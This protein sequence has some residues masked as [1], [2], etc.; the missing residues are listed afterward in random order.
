MRNFVIA[1]ALSLATVGTV[2]AAAL[3]G[4]F[5]MFDPN[6]N[7]VTDLSWGTVCDEQ[8]TGTIVT[9]ANGDGTFAVSSPQSFFGDLWFAHDGVTFGPGTHTFDTIEGGVY[10][11]I[12]VAPG[13]IGGHL[14]FDWGSASAVT[15]C[16]ITNCDIDVVNIWDVTLSSVDASTILK[17]YISTDN[18]GRATGDPNLP[19]DPYDLQDGILGNKIIDV[20]FFGFGPNFNFSAQEPDSTPPV[21]TLIG[22]N[23]QSVVIGDT[24]T[25][26]GADCVDAAPQQAFTYTP[27]ITGT[28]DTATLGDYIVT[29]NC[30]DAN[31]NSATPVTRTVSVVPADAVATLLGSTPVNYECEDTVATYVDAGAEC[32]DPEDG[33]WSDTVLGIPGTLIELTG[34]PFIETAPGGPH[35]LTWTCTDTDSNTGTAIREVNVVDTL[36]PV[37]GPF[38]QKDP[39]GTLLGDVLTLETNDEVAYANLNPTLESVTDSCDTTL[40]PLVMTGDTVDFVIVSGDVKTSTLNYTTTDA[41]GNV[42]NTP[43]TVNV[44]RSE[45][46][47]TLIGSAQLVLNVGDAYVEQGMDVHDEQDG[48]LTAVTTSGITTGVGAGA[49]DLTHNIVIRDA[50][51]T[52]VQSVDTSISGVIYTILYDVTDSDLNVATQVIRTVNVGGVFADGSNFTM[53]QAKGDT[54]G[55]TNDVIFDW[56]QSLNTAESDTNF[57]MEIST[58]TP[59]PFNGAVWVAHHIRAFG[60]GTYY[61]ETDNSVCT[62]AVLQATG[63]PGTAGSPTSMEMIVGPDQVGAHILFDWNGVLNIDVVNVWDRNAVWDDFGD[64][65]PRNALFLGPGGSPP[66][67]TKPF[68]LVTTTQ[69]TDVNG[70]VHGS[71]MI[72]G[73]FVGFYANFNAGPGGVGEAL[74]P[75][76]SAAPDTSI[77]ASSMSV[78]TMLTG[79]FSLLGLR[80][81]SRK[82]IR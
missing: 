81:A 64:T 9:D 33:F 69:F 57:N 12:V 17:T 68:K 27:V 53:L 37:P 23:P 80:I 48:D 70:P 55:G 24:Y 58:A 49:G 15:P 16:G 3:A 73:P 22:A 25:E 4:E 14:L 79:L 77:G 10:E 36:T 72:D 30:D 2:H 29:Y 51:S 40:A 41:S 38:T 62:V 13:Q 59:T 28:V 47:I 61:F 18:P 52:I 76:V 43:L 78:W 75:I 34:L 8:V 31:G 19:S 65:P 71:P 39:V 60:P 26:L 56:D 7:P 6:G 35:N 42:M 50:S 21:I 44:H 66:D 20:T 32:N 63:C 67:V 5:C 46:V 82:T 54:F 1:L 45:P 11:D 74:P